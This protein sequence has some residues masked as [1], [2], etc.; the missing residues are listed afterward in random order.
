VLK[1]HFAPIQN[2]AGAVFGII[3]FLKKACAVYKDAHAA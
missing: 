2:C 1:L 3:D